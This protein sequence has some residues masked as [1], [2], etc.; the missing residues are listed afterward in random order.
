[1]RLEPEEPVASRLRR[2][3]A[4]RDDYGGSCLLFFYMRVAEEKVVEGVAAK[5]E[6]RLRQARLL[7]AAAYPHNHSTN[8]CGLE[9]VESGRDTQSLE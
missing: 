2:G 1:M 9:I 5:T 6:R 4:G 8:R 7:F 3:P